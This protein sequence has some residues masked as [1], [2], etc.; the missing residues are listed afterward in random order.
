MHAPG[1]KDDRSYARKG[2]RP[3]P[4]PIN[5]LRRAQYEDA[6]DDSTI[7]SL[8]SRLET[9]TIDTTTDNSTIATALYSSS[10]G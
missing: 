5:D 9:S 8:A 7:T 3:M 2:R 10:L 6:G 1:L 4:T